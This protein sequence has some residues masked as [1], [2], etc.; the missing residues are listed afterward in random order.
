MR[1]DQS[2]QQSAEILRMVLPHFPRHSA[3][4]HPI[5]FALWYEFTAGINPPLSKRIEELLA[6][7]RTIDDKLAHELYR[8]YILD[9]WS[10]RSLEVNHQLEGLVST[11]EQSAER[12][13]ADT[14]QFDLAWHAFEG[15]MQRHAAAQAGPAAA[16]LMETGQRMRTT[17]QDLRTELQ[18]SIADTRKLKEELKRLHNEVLTDPLTGLVNRRGLDAAFEQIHQDAA[19]YGRPCSAILVDVDHFKRVNDSFG[20]LFG[21]QVLKSVAGTLRQRARDTDL[22]ARLGGEEF[23]IVLPDTDARQAQAVAEDMR[24]FV[25]RAELRSRASA[26]MITKITISAG[27]TARRPQDTTTEMIARADSAMYRAKSRGRN[28]VALVA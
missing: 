16:Q 17:V 6:E 10:A 3:A 4:Y 11:F 26:A 23:L 13:R 27:V 5:S 2:V 7:G 19:Q 18:A 12:A 25:E 21:D 22:V 9:A 24:A 15:D 8:E 20:H 14:D 28:Q 1:Y